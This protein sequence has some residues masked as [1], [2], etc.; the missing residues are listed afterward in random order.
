MTFH[1]Y[2]TVPEQTSQKRL[3]LQFNSISIS[4]KRNFIQEVPQL[5]QKN[6]DIKSVTFNKVEDQP[7]YQQRLDEFGTLSNNI[8]TPHNHSKDI[9]ITEKR[10]PYLIN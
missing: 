2:N 9:N 4:A 10:Q 7:N 1:K 3:K 5:I 6:N 8:S